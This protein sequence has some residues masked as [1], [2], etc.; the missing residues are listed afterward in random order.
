LPPDAIQKEL[1][2][3]L[4]AREATLGMGRL[5]ADPEAL[6]DMFGGFT[7]AM[8]DDDEEFDDEDEFLEDW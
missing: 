3:L 2:E 1:L 7:D 4:G 5:L 6:L 8:Y